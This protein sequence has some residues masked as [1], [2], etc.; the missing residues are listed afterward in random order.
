MGSTRHCTDLDQEHSIVADVIV[1]FNWPE[2]KRF[3]K[4]YAIYF[5]A[6]PIIA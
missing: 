3:M 2:L 1:V 6:L 4:H 5:G